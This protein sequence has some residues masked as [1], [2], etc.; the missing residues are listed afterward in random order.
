MIR[1]KKGTHTRF[2]DG[3]IYPGWFGELPPE[4]RKDIVEKAGPEHR[5]E[6]L[7]D[8]SVVLPPLACRELTELDRPMLLL[9]GEKSNARMLLIT[10]ELEECLDGESHVMVPEVGHAMFANATFINDAVLAFLEG[11]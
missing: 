11:Q 1:R 6:M 9:T 8:R 2:L 10:A 3:V 7:T 4:V 5:L